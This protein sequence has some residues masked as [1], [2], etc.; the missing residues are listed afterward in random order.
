MSDHLNIISTNKRI[1]NTLW[2]IW[3]LIHQYDLEALQLKRQHISL[4]L[5]KINVHV[6]YH[7]RK[8]RIVVEQMDNCCF[9]YCRWSC[10]MRR[11][12][13]YLHILHTYKLF[14]DTYIYY[15]IHTGNILSCNLSTWSDL[16]KPSLSDIRITN[17]SSTAVSS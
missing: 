2:G 13:H 6:L 15:G 4:T 14:M 11:L 3:L 1:A 5:L 12:V 10:I 17:P 16:C 9:I 8:G 7:C